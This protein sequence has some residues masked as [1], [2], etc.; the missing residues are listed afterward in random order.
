MKITLTDKEAGILK[1]LL[2]TEIDTTPVNEITA[3]F[4]DT[5]AGLLEKLNEEK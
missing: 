3:F 2:R 4:L 1:E 5:I